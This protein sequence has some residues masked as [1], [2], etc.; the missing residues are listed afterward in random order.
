MLE[1]TPEG[2]TDSINE[3]GEKGDRDLILDV[4][5][6]ELTRGVAYLAYIGGFIVGVILSFF[7]RRPLKAGR[8]GA[9]WN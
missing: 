8:S 1:V 5:Q 2:I 7:F 6:I 4:F 9:A 3:E